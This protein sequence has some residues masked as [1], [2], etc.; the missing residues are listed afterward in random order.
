MIVQSWQT[1]PSDERCMDMARYVAGCFS[2]RLPAAH[3]LVAAL[4][5]GDWAAVAKHNVNYGAA[6]EEVYLA[7]QIIA[8]FKKAPFLPVDANPT[9]AAFKKFVESEANCNRVNK[10]F[11]LREEGRFRLSLIH[12]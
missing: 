5:R 2:D 1:P 11:R 4:A 6:P 7:S 9:E 3:P 10:L 12:I 8:L